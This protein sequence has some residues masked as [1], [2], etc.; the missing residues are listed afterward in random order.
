MSPSVALMNDPRAARGSL[1][2][3]VPRRI[4]VLPGIRASSAQ[5]NIYSIVLIG[6]A[7]SLGGTHCMAFTAYLT[8]SISAH[9]D[10]NITC[11]CLAH[12]AKARIIHASHL[13]SATKGGRTADRFIT[14]LPY[15]S[16]TLRL[17]CS[18]YT[19]SQIPG[20]VR[21]EQM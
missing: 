19:Y 20:R 13:L 10:P 18:Y 14:P 21:K 1:D 8:F 11:N 9:A 2:T 17:A 16:A 4:V 3:P 5:S 6:K 12:Y 7:A 15:L